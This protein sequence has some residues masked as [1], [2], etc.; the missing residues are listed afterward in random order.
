MEWVKPKA[1]MIAETCMNWSA[2][3]EM[4]EALRIP[5]WSPKG[6]SSHGEVLA[7]VGGRLCYKSFDTS[8]NGN[9]TQVREGNYDYIGNILQQGH[10]SVLE[11][12]YATFVLL[13]VSRI[14]THELVRHRAGMA[15]S[16]ES[17]RFVRI[18][19][20]R[21]YKPH[22]LPEQAYIIMETAARAAERYIE[23]MMI[24]CGMHDPN[25]PFSEKKRFTSAIRRIAPSGM[26]NDIMVTANHRAWRHILQMR[27]SP[28]AEDEIQYITCE[29]LAP[30]LQSSFPAFYQDMLIRDGAVEFKYKKV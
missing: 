1:Y 28:G 9:L 2:Y 25:M 14:F 19:N 30:Q 10:G 8:L 4:K 11:H 15:F 16:Q 6:Y 26:T 23:D 18:D 22:N 20:I 27:G 12:S 21:M 24:A 7:E 3:Q 29:E 13:N 17:G 5:D